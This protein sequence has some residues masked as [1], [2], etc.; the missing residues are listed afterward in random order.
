MRKETRDKIKQVEAL[1]AGGEN[2]YKAIKQIG[3]GIGS[4]QKYT[5]RRS[6]AVKKKEP[7]GKAVVIICDVSKLK[8]VLNKL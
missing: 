5:N 8:D 7:E 6:F 3:L 1:V 2:T 4:W